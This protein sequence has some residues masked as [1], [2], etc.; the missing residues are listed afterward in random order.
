[1]RRI[2]LNIALTKVLHRLSWAAWDFRPVRAGKAAPSLESARGA[3]LHPCPQNRA[4]ACACA[5]MGRA[6]GCEGFCFRSWGAGR[7]GSLGAKTGVNTA[8]GWG[9]GL[10]RACG[11]ASSS[12]SRGLPIVQQLSAGAVKLHL[13]LLCSSVVRYAEDGSC[14]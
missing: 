10:A 2:L 8:P 1:M 4:C 7:T 9:A 13:E 6:A 14:V 5:A 3:A 12:H 11:A